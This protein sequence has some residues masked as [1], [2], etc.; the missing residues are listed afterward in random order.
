MQGMYVCLFV[1]VSLN[2]HPILSTLPYTV[3]IIM[4]ITLQMSPFWFI[5]NYVDAV[6]AENVQRFC[7]ESQ[8]TKWLPVVHATAID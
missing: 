4:S 3:L 5:Q 8:I 6:A 2:V 1:T 7:E